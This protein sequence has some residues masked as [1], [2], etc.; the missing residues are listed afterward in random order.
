M[1]S[2]LQGEQ[3][4]LAKALGHGADSGKETLPP[5][6]V[7]S[8]PG[9]HGWEDRESCQETPEL[10]LMDMIPSGQEGQQPLGRVRGSVASRAGQ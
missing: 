4:G 5:A 3:R 8:V 9:R 6:L 2:E 7:C 1:V 10:W